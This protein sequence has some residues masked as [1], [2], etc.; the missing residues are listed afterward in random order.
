MDQCVTLT[1]D[2]MTLAVLF[3]T[4]RRPAGT[5]V[6]PDLFHAMIRAFSLLALRSDIETKRLLSDPRSI[7]PNTDR[8]P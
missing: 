6:V 5:C 3:K 4:V 2:V 8:S 7:T 1:H